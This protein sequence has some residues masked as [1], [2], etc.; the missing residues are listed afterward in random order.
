METQW[1]RCQDLLSGVVP[2]VVN[3]FRLTDGEH[4]QR[5]VLQLRRAFRKADVSDT[6]AA[7]RM[8]VRWQERVPYRSRAGRP[9]WARAS[10][11]RARRPSS[12]PEW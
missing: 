10:R 7:S 1:K 12:V 6:G 3:Q 8:A 4:A 11:R 5:V 2:V 9:P